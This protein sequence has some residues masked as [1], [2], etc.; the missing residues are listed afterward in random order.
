MKLKICGLK[1]PD[2]ILEVAALAPDFMG[3][4]F[5]SESKRFV[6]NDFVMPQ[7]P[8]S[9]KRVGVFVERRESFNDTNDKSIGKIKSAVEKYRLDFVQLHGNEFPEY[10]KKISK[11]VKIIKAFAVDEHFDFEKVKKYEEFCDYFLFDTKTELH[12]GSGKQFDWSL[13]KRY[14]SKTPYFISGGIGLEDI[15]KLK[16]IELTIFGMDVNSKFEKEPGLKDI[17]LLKKIT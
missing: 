14:V 3:F 11:H 2:N 5:Y 8:S 1:H 10:C 13:L 4:I 15:E 9:I 16:N 12:G 17:D 7:I 6:G